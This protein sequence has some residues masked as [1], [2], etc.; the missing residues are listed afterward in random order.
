MYEPRDSIRSHTSYGPEPFLNRPPQSSLIRHQAT[1]EYMPSHMTTYNKN[2]SPIGSPVEAYLRVDNFSIPK[3]KATEFSH[4]II[5]PNIFD[6]SSCEELSAYLIQFELIAERHEWND[7]K[8][9]QVLFSKLRGEAMNIVNTVT[10]RQ[11]SHYKVLKQILIQGFQS[12]KTEREFKDLFFH[13]TQNEFETPRSYAQRLQHIYSKAFP[14][15]GNTQVHN[16]LVKQFI[17]GL[18]SEGLRQYVQIKKAAYL[19]DA[20]EITETYL[21]D[22]PDGEFKAAKLNFQI[23]T[24]LQNTASNKTEFVTQGC[25]AS[26]KTEFVT[27]GCSTSNKTEVVTQDCSTPNKTEVVTQSCSTP[28]KEEVVTQGCSTTN[29]TEFV[30]QGCSIPNKTEVV[31]QGCISPKEMKMSINCCEEPLGI[32]VTLEDGEQP[33]ENSISIEGCSQSSEPKIS[34]VGHRQ[35]NDSINGCEEPLGIKVTLEDGEQ[36]DENRISIEGY[37]QSSKPKISTVGH[38]QPNDSKTSNIGHSQPNNCKTSNIGH[39]QPNESKTLNNSQSQPNE[40]RLLNED[41]NQQIDTEKAFLCYK[42]QIDNALA[43]LYSTQSRTELNN[44]QS[45]PELSNKEQV[46]EIDSC[47]SLLCNSEYGLKLQIIETESND[48]LLSNCENE[49]KSDI[50]QSESDHSTN[51]TE[52]ESCN[53]G[54]KPV[55]HGV[56]SESLKSSHILENA[57]NGCLASDINSTIRDIDLIQSQLLAAISD[58]EEVHS[59]EQIPYAENCNMIPENCNVCEIDTLCSDISEREVIVESVVCDITYSSDHLYLD[60]LFSEQAR[61]CTP[62]SIGVDFEAGDS[63]QENSERPYAV[64]QMISMTQFKDQI[65]NMDKN[66]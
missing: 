36:P 3:T 4:R 39:S 58:P 11:C 54:N 33:D 46:D 24:D 52:L 63:A 28:H 61:N 1:N 51:E 48:S 60:K 6:G 44:S 66:S 12:L 19:N 29:K 15:T 65:S 35:P 22:L 17:K 49:S 64:R 47:D 13:C 56:K 20:V 34:I 40:Y 26:N 31:T 57:Q 62:E 18:R 16:D 14:R 37:S 23:A 2:T 10:Y 21:L 7:T 43:K 9:A 42:P 55:Q 50:I 59:H 45:E 32:K 5:E 41:C 8:K 38:R 30:T 53:R 25:S 27:Q